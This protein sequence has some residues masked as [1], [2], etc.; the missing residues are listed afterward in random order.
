MSTVEAQKSVHATVMKRSEEPEGW[1]LEVEIPTFQS[2][3][4]THLTRVPKSTADLLSPGTSHKLL[5]QRENLKKNREGQAQT[6]DRL[7]HWYWGLVKIL[8]PGE[9]ADDDLFPAESTQSAPERRSG[10]ELGMIYGNSRNVVATLIAS[11]IAYHG[12]LPNDDEVHA[13]LEVHARWVDID[14]EVQLNKRKV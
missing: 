9:E 12:E 2:S 4:P 3:W 13:M 8:L 1:H 14:F 10:M 5:L 11:H 7:F 6:G